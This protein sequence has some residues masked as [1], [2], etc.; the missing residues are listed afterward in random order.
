MLVIIIDRWFSNWGPEPSGFIEGVTPVWISYGSELVIN[1]ITAPME[2]RQSKWRGEF[3]Y[4]SEVRYTVYLCLTYNE[5]FS[6][7][8]KT[9][10]KYTLIM[11]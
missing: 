11:P 10:T 1:D 4:Y 8:T 9:N 2:A 7:S 6:A 3:N 5:T